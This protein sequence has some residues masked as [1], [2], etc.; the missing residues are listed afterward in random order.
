[1]P[2]LH[3]RTERQ[4]CTKLDQNAPVSVAL[5]RVSP[6]VLDENGAHFR[7]SI[8]ESCRRITFL[9][10]KYLINPACCAPSAVEDN[11]ISHAKKPLLLHW[12]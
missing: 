7:D 2:K 4:V 12:R 6:Q 1:M 5:G 3:L 11:W 10:V 9:C 8:F